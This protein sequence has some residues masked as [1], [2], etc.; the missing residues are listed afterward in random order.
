RADRAVRGSA[1]QA[2]PDS[3]ARPARSG[4]AGPTAGRSREPQRALDRSPPARAV[5]AARAPGPPARA[6]AVL[7]KKFASSRWLP[8]RRIPYLGAELALNYAELSPPRFPPPSPGDGCETGESPGRR[9]EGRDDPGLVERV[10]LELRAERQHP[11]RVCVGPSADGQWHSDRR[12]RLWNKPRRGR[13]ET[14]EHDQVQMPLAK[15]RCGSDAHLL[16]VRGL[17]HGQGHRPAR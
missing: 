3:H 4:H 15:P 16:Q 1:R 2:E 13:S 6:R 7:T 17:S 8:G 14:S 11:K 12:G 9:D 5:A 10:L